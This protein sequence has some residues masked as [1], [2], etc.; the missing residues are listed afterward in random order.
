MDRIKISE[1]QRAICSDRRLRG[2]CPPK[3]V[4]LEL[5]AQLSWCRIE[6]GSY[7]IAVAQPRVQDVLSKSER[8]VL[9][10][11]NDNGNVIEA[12]KF[13]SLCAAKGIGQQTSWFVVYNSPIILREA[14]GVYA[15]VGTTVGVPN[16]LLPT[17][18]RTSVLLDYGWR[19][20]GNLWLGFKLS[21]GIIR[22]GVFGVPTRMRHFLHGELAPKRTR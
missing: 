18:R 8:L 1:F 10:V 12:R 19:P 3:E 20:N 11:L 5:C 13:I 16:S 2:F 14:H 4:L 9:Q 22:S 6:D 21:R 15:L 17:L 7:I